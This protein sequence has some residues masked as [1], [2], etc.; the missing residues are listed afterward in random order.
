MKKTVL[1]LAF[2]IYS[3]FILSIACFGVAYIEIGD[4]VTF[5]SYNGQSI[6]WRC[7]DINE[8][9]PL[10][11]SD[12]ILC[13]KAYDVAGSE[14]DESHDYDSQT[15]YYRGMFGSDRWE[16]SNIRTWL[17]ST[18]QTVEYPCGNAPTE[19]NSFLEYNAYAKEAGFLSS[20]NF[21]ADD[22][23]LMKNVYHKS[24][25]NNIEKADANSG[26]EFLSYSNNAESAVLNYEKA[27][28]ISLSDKVFLPDVQNISAIAKN[29]ATPNEVLVAYPTSQAVENSDYESAD[30][31][32][33]T[34]SKYW[35]STPHNENYG[36]GVRTVD[37]KGNVNVNYA[38]TVG[39]G[40][41]PAFYLNTDACEL[42]SGNGQASSPYTLQINSREYIYTT[43]VVKS[44]TNDVS[45]MLNFA[46]F[47]EGTKIRVMTV[48]YKGSSILSMNTNEYDTFE[49]KSIAFS[50]G[51]EADTIK[52]FAW[53]GN[54]EIPLCSAAIVKLT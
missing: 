32:L 11:I 16:D 31:A 52:F 21:S 44:K 50:A 3:Y 42:A 54:K 49:A 51:Q 26:S 18:S 2:L 17:N 47:A 5:G 1:K 29:F 9:G 48:C 41:R 28:G 12:K 39:V 43:N 38:S 35:L 27:Y 6:V 25:I 53:V 10:M 13:Y 4:Y 36:D 14:Q 15:A 23:K 8:N 24:V 45:L 19:E 46:N 34:A 7:V 33:Q 20:T 40:V 37:D 22:I 30:I